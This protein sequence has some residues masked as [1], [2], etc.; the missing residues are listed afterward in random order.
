[1]SPIVSSNTPAPV[2]LAKSVSRSFGPVIALSDVTIA[3]HAGSVHAITGEN[4]AGKS[5]LMKILAGVVSPSQGH[6]ERDGTVM[7]FRS[8]QDARRAGISTVFQE[9]TLLPNLT[10]SENLAL[11]REPGW[12]PF[13][14]AAAMRGDAAKVLQKIGFERNADT[15]AGALSV[16]EQQMVEIAKGL[17]AD[18][19]VFIFDEPTAALNKSEV[20]KLESIILT[21]REARKTIFYISHRLDEI[22][23]VCDTVSV[24]K[25]GKLVTTRAADTLDEQTLV[26]L[27]VGR[28]VGFLY[29]QRA[30]SQGNMRLTCS[31]LVVT[32]DWKPV[33]LSL[34]QGEII[35]LAGLEGQGQRELVRALAGVS[36]PISAK[37]FKSDV[38]GRDIP[39]RPQLGVVACQKA[40]VGFVPGDR[41]G[42]G[43]YLDLSVSDNI[44]I[45]TLKSRMLFGRATVDKVRVRRI[46]TDLGV[47][48]HGLDQKVGTLSGGNQQKV[49][50]ARL[51]AAGVDTLLIE[52]PTRGVDVGARAEIYSLLRRFTADGGAILLTSSDL[53]ELLGL[54]DRILVVRG[55]DIVGEVKG[56]EA[57]EET[58]MTLALTGRHARPLEKAI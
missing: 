37:I 2:I 54:C 55:R 36:A 52:E 6:V 29:P 53:P 23:R 41:K 45:G 43:L 20:Q 5:T 58:V 27:M 19:S 47:K 8:P 56:E 30:T 14:S 15:L 38:T 13:V 18:A 40:G 10:V 22:F 34:H 7:R 51:L 11:G 21:L 24:M 26:N 12:G 33:D 31:E 42:E 1:M 57:T 39:Y 3:G 17:M 32:D 9:F 16:G 49:L 25:D 44:S 50:L 46:A 28:E 35:G 48:T 4:G